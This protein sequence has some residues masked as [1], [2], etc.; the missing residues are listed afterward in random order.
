MRFIILFIFFGYDFSQEKKVSEIVI[1]NT[2]KMNSDFI[3]KI[4]ETKVEVLLIA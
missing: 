3:L 4:I 1:S 2:K